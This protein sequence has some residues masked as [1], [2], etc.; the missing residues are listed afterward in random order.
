MKQPDSLVCLKKRLYRL[1][2]HKVD[3]LPLEGRQPR[4]FEINSDRL[5]KY[6]LLTCTTSCFY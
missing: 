3:D 5:N 4:T 6:A 2:P 1:P